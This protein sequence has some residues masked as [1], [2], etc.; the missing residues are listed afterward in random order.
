MAPKTYVLRR[1]HSQM[2]DLPRAQVIASAD[3]AVDISRNNFPDTVIITK[4]TAAA[5]TLA[6]PTAG[7]PSRGGHD[8][9]RIRF[10]STTAA[11]HTVTNSSPG[12]NNGST[13]SDVGTF[14]AAIGNGFEVEAY[15][16]IWYIIA[17]INVTFA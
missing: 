4:G 11:A 15:N 10:V 8:G 12:F 9:L 3:G 2:G 5:L 1:F 14:A 17:N 16:G 7:K 13:A 6:A